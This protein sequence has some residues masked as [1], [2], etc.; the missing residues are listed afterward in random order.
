MTVSIKTKSNAK[1]ITITISGNELKQ[2]QSANFYHCEQAIQRVVNTIGLDLTREAL[3]NKET[4]ADTIESGGKTW[5][6]KD[7]ST[8]RYLSLYGEV[9]VNR[10][11]Y[12]TSAGGPTLCPLEE[13]CGLCFGQ[14]TP[15]L[16]EILSF[17]V[18]ALTPNEVAQDLKKHG[19]R[20]SA[21]FI[22]QTAQR[23]GRIAV[24]KQEKWQLSAASPQAVVATIATGFDGTT[25]PLRDEGYKE[26]MCGTIALY[27]LKGE[28]L[29]TEYL[30]SMPESGKA[31]FT[32][33]L[34]DRVAQ[35]RELY[36]R[37]IH[38]VLSDG[39][40]WNWQ[41]IKQ[42]YPDSI[43]ILDFWH[44]AQ[45]LGE[46][47]DAIFGKWPS[48][49]KKDWF[50]RWKTTLRDEP[51]GVAGVIRTMLY[52]RNRGHLSAEAAR[53][54]DAQL[55][56]FRHHA[57][58]MQYADYSAAGFPIGSGV[59]EAG[60]KELIKARFSRSGMRWKRESG[61]NI[62]HLRAIRLSNQWDCFWRK[63]VRY[64]A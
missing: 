11:L 59:T 63:V 10:H 9:L 35:V 31:R 55:N 22:Q 37:A 53:E 42:H 2:M 6:R 52:Y 3:Q 18:A 24:A 13:D 46:A 60:C 62:L 43:W 12:Q 34:L 21:D 19:L 23:V 51:N 40:L 14:A 48:P 44:A 57:E 61:D 41:L 56:Y 49:D 28:R 36:P 45:H 20:V 4:T 16:A 26:A 50:D 17:K 32:D 30:G 5:Y 15:L 29:S 25:V 27:N 58:H 8:G 64:V 7:A 1:S 47:A 54:L 38:V 33:R 39:A